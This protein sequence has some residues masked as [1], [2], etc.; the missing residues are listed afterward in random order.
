ML[1][2]KSK[3]QAMIIGTQYSLIQELPDIIKSLSKLNQT[4]MKTELPLLQL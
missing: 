1:I 3:K 2:G 4:I